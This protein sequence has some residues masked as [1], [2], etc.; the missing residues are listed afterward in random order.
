MDATQ[1][2]QNPSAMT[3]T[4]YFSGVMQISQ[5]L[6][7]VAFPLFKRVGDRRKL[8]AEH[9]VY[10]VLNSMANPWVNALKW[11]ESVF[12]QVIN[13]GNSYS[14]IE[15]DNSYRPKAVYL[16]DPAR[17]TVEMKESGEPV[18][19]YRRNDGTPITFN[20]KQIFNLAGFGPDA[21]TGWAAITLFREA[22]RLGISMQTFANSFITK[23]VHT[24][25]IVSHPETLG[26]EAKKNLKKSLDEAYAGENNAGRVL[27]FEEGM[28][29][30][31]T[32]M[33]LVDAEF[34]G[35]RVFQIQEIARMLNM[36]LHKLKDMSGA[37]YSN[38]EHQQIEWVTD[39]LRPWSERMEIA[40]DTQ[41]LTPI[42][43][44]KGFS[45]HAM[46]QLQ[47]GD[48]KTM[49]ET[50]RIGR[51]AGIYSANKALENL[52]ENPLDDDE[53][54]NRLW[55]PSNMMNADSEAAKNG[56]GSTGVTSG[57]GQGGDDNEDN[58]DKKMV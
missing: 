27:V 43:R 15:R 20:T 28:T 30:T 22:L 9:P 58:E 17:M 46:N 5:S 53:I 7:S 34:L 26:E 14:F 10:N 4:A 18:Y 41:L 39:T 44:K 23:G 40:V 13:W 21:Y 38:I 16:L 33:S 6:A 45:Q 12:Q 31:P 37:T 2:G 1:V 55:Q 19:T 8:W 51:F 50:Q 48:M 3:Y 56:G 47:R 24:S 32:S 29:W 54:G 49:M 25:G 11:R 42:E 57:D 35:S 36:P 52:G